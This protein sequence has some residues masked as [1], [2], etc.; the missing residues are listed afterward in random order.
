VFLHIVNVCFEVRILNI[1]NGIYRLWEISADMKKNVYSLTWS[2]KKCFKARTN[3]RLKYRHLT[4][5]HD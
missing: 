5:W 3:T 1:V 2:H 4:P